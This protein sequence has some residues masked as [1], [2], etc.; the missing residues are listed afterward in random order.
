MTGM[1]IFHIVIA[2]VLMTRFVYYPHYDCLG[3][4][5]LVCLLYTL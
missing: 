1:L 3:Y 5:D 4:N 2:Q